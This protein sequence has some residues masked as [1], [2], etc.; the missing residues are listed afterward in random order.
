MPTTSGNSPSR[1]YLSI[2]EYLFD[3]ARPGGMPE[4]KEAA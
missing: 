4:L 2:A 1:Q 3:P